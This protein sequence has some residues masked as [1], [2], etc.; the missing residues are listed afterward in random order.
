MEQLG[1]PEEI[2]EQPA[3]K[4]IADFVTQAN[5]I[6]AHR[7]AGG[8]QTALGYVDDFMVQPTEAV[9]G[10]LM[11]RQEELQLSPIDASETALIIC[12]REFLGREY[13]YTLT[14]PTQGNLQARTSSRLDVGSSVHITIKPN[15][16]GLR[17]F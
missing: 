17:L 9:T 13:K 7:S 12:D 15:P 1:S 8:W 2:Y 11:L 16:S 10:T 6:E 14:H 3:S 5:F 4:F